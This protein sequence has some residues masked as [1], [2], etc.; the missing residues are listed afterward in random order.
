[1]KKT[2]IK[3]LNAKELQAAL[4]LVWDVFQKYE[5]VN[6]PEEGK[7]LFYQAIHDPGYLSTLKAYGAFEGKELVGIIATREAGK[8]VALFFVDGNYHG[9]G[10]GRRLW[11]ELMA[12]NDSKEITVHSSIYAQE[13]YKKLG[14][15]QTGEMQEE[16]GMQFIPMTYTR[17]YKEDCPCK[18]TKC[19]SHGICMECRSRHKDSDRPR[20]CER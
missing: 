16:D 19:A 13:V 7:Q 8:H 5:A 2:K 10:I 6:Y 20:P 15:E 12:E 18:K 11:N 9:Q 1:M 17:K 3:E 14:F 4:P